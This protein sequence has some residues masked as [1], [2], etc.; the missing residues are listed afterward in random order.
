MK[1]LL[2]VAFLALSSNADA[3]VSCVNT[4]Y[5]DDGSTYSDTASWMIGDSPALLHGLPRDGA[6]SCTVNGHE[7][8]YVKATFQGLRNK[9]HA[10]QVVYVGDD[11]LFIVENL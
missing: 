1:K 6:F 9:Q 10:S 3:V 5:Y 11:A 7:L 4:I 2:F 8:A